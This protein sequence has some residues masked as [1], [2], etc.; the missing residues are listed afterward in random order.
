MPFNEIVKGTIWFG[1]LD[2]SGVG[3]LQVGYYLFSKESIFHL[4]MK[5]KYLFIL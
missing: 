3:S 2:E 1:G 5:L 4:Y